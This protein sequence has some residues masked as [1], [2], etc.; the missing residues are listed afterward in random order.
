MAIVKHQ[1]SKNANY[2]GVL[3]YYTLKHE[4][5]QKTGHYEPILD[6]YGFTQ[7]RDNYSVC[8]ISAQ[9]EEKEPELWAAA[10]MRTNML[11]RKNQHEGDRK[12]HEYIISHPAE[13]RERMTMEDLMEEGRAFVREHL[14][15]Y[16]ALI[17]VH[18]DTD[19]DHIH[20]SINSV[21]A[22]QRE[23][24]QE[25][26]MKDKSGQVLACEMEAG[27]KHQDSPQLRRCMNDWLLE[28]SRQHG[29]TR[30]D[31]NAKADANKALRH[32]S[33][34]EQMKTALLEAAGRSKDVREL[35]DI[36]KR[37]YNMEL[38]IR[39]NTFSIQ[40]PDSQKAVRLRTLGVEP[41]DI[42]RRLQGQEFTYT[43]ATEDQQIQ[44]QIEAEEK[45]KY[46][47]WVRERRYRN[48]SRAEAIVDKAMRKLGQKLKS[49]GLKYNKLEFQDLRY[50]IKETA[51][52]SAGLQTEKD[53]LD[54]LLE[55]WEKYKDASLP[56]QERRKHAGYVKWCGCDPD[57]ALEFEGLKSE[58]EVIEAQRNHT[59]ALRKALENTAEKWRGINNLTYS[60]NNLAW[61][62]QREHQLKNQLRN[63]R[64]SRMKL[65]E[66]A[67]NCERAASKHLFSFDNTK[68][69][70]A[71]YF[72][73]LWRDKL[74]KEQEIQKKIREI[75]KKKREA[76]AKYRQARKNARHIER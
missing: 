36:L 12:S 60:E 28:Y 59:I 18:R 27:G 70:K 39:G 40:H 48:N 65:G 46:I 26:M 30:E 1:S 14:A 5:S 67:T 11:F 10:C 45:K 8:Y 56:E 22:L 38:K 71:Q 58:R 75:K 9:G 43:K 73:E 35:Q 32:G 33:K 13:D 69:E 66:I 68:W 7:E 62:K 54:R 17:A 37:E 63:V 3:D 19:N 41:A 6:E 16:D 72:R 23:R 51:Y 29:Y 61:T 34:N 42:T 21:R 47:D 50:L 25:W 15:G 49:E 57:S 53:K 2:S 64:A 44:K 4:E 52:I 31:N 74:R 20:I 24:E 55:R 76:K